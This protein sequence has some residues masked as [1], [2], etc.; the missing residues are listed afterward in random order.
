MY[1]YIIARFLKGSK[2]T[3][4]VEG[5]PVVVTGEYLGNLAGID[6]VINVKLEHGGPI[7]AIDGTKISF[8]F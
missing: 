4:A 1:A 5:L 6:S 7:V 8:V 3:I 2:I